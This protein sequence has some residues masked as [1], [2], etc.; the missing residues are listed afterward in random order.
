MAW[1]QPLAAS[2]T[3]A[4]SVMSPGTTS[5]RGSS[6]STPSS[7]RFSRSFAGVRTN[8]RTRWPSSRRRLEDVDAEEPGCTREHDNGHGPSLSPASS[9]GQC[10]FGW[11]STPWIVWRAPVPGPAVVRRGD[12]VVV[13]AEEVLRVVVRL[14]L[15]EALEIRLVEGALDAYGDGFV[16]DAR[17][18]QVQRTGAEL[19]HLGPG[20]SHPRDDLVVVARVLP[21][22]VHR[23]HPVRRALA[24]RGVLGSRRG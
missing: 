19:V 16:G 18:V 14:D 8:A 12:D 9:E 4:A 5:M 7:A 6:G 20:A 17:E 1:S 13:Q 2:L 23:H 21:V 24:V 11:S 22:A 15:L 3:A 10:H